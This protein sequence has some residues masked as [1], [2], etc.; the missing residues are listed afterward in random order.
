VKRTAIAVSV[1]CFMSASDAFAFDWSVKTTESETVE[2]NSNQILRD[3]PAGSVG[4][5][6]TL[7]ANAEARTPTGTFD[8]D[9]DGTYRK[10]WGPGIAGTASEF[11]SYGFKARYEQREKNK[12]DKEYVEASWRQQSTA[13]A[14]LNDLGVTSGLNGFLDRMTISGGIDRSLSAVD[15]LSLFATSTRTSYEPSAGGTAFTD[16]LARASWRHALSST[17]GVS[18]SSE[19]ELLDYDNA[20][21]T[22]IQIFRNQVGIDSSLSA[23]LSFRGNVGAA[24]LVTEG[25]ATTSVLGGFPTVSSTSSTVLDWV[26]DAVLPNAEEH[27]LDRHRESIGRPEYRRLPLQARFDRREPYSTH[28]LAIQLDLL[29]ER[30]QTDFNGDD[31]LRLGFS[32]LQLQPDSRLAGPVHVSLSSSL[33]E[34]G[35]RGLRSDHRHSDCLRHGSGRLAQHH[36]RRD[37]Q[38]HIVASRKLTGVYLIAAWILSFR[39]V[40]S[41]SRVAATFSCSAA[42]S[43]I[44]APA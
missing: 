8:F 5:Y 42:L 44:P 31:G 19:G 25:G 28:Q 37:P 26:G 12:F 27:D 7:T 38:L 36:G 21:G 18:L 22:S 20:L 17:T 13:L 3:S 11:L 6:S 9:G 43:G 29:G 30:K 15:T 32:R 24:Y 16:T 41:G 34:F 39:G 23:L 33:R 4:S 2:L 10:Y 40:P 14:L 1:C 35:H